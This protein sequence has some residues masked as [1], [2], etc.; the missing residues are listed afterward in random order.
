MSQ[1]VICPYCHGE[2]VLES[3]AKVYNGKNFGL[4]YICPNFPSCDSYVGVHKGTKTPLGVMANREHRELKKRCHDLFDRLWKSKKR[5]RGNAYLI[6]QKMMNLPPEA[7]H[8]GM[9]TLEQCRE[10]IAKLELNKHVNATTKGV[11]DSELY[12][13]IP[14]D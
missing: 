9:F 12:M 14:F 1:R 13:R 8:I 10:L 3:S 2:A 6:L 5:S 4:M 11:G 7:A